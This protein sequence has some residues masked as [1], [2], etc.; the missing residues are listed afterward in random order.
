MW[1]HFC[2]EIDKL[3]IPVIV[4]NIYA[5]VFI[6]TALFLVE[7]WKWMNS[8]KC[9]LMYLINSYGHILQILVSIKNYGF[10]LVSERTKKWRPFIFRKSG[11]QN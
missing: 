11:Q 7:K 5:N 6:N 3:Y 10:I 8:T 2:C 1:S 9:F 4:S